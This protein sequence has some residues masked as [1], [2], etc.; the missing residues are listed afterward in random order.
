[1]ILDLQI[2]ILSIQPRETLVTCFRK[3]CWSLKHTKRGGIKLINAATYLDIFVYLLAY[4]R[5][6]ERFFSN[7]NETIH[8]KR[9]KLCK[10]YVDN[11]KNFVSAYT[12]TEKLRRFFVKNYS[13]INHCSKQNIIWNFIPPYS[14]NFSNLQETSVKC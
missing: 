5:F 7:V 4:I 14:L 11:G 9:E 6:N 10:I 2:T 8:S 12:E 13:F 3:N 1:M